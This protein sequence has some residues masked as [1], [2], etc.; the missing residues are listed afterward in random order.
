MLYKRKYSRILLEAIDW[1]MEI[2]PTLRPQSID[3]FLDAISQ[4]DA[5][6]V[7]NG[8]TNVI[9]RIVNRFPWRK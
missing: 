4:N 1:A 8:G 3:V 7:A 5:K 2:D 6:H 9:D